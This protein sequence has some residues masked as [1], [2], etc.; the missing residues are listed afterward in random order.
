MI[1]RIVFL[2]LGTA[3]LLFSVALAFDGHSPEDT[4]VTILSFPLAG[5][6]F[7][8]G[9]VAMAIAEQRKK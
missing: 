4:P 3:A 6:G 7:M 9:A 1:M 5:V 2:V 8:I